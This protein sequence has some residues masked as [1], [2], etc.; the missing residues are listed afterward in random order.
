M[1]DAD[2]EESTNPLNFIKFKSVQFKEACR[3]EDNNGVKKAKEWRLI[4]WD[5]PPPGWYKFNTD[6]AMKASCQV[7]AA[8]GILR[9]DQGNWLVGFAMNLGNYSALVAEIWGAWKALNLAWKKGYRKIILEMD[10][11]VAIQ[12]ITNGTNSTNAATR[13]VLDIRRM[14]KLDW[15]VQVNH[16]FRE[17]NR[18]ADTLANISIRLPLGL[19]E[20]E[21]VPKEVLDIVYQDAVGV[22]FDRLCN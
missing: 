21:V 9:N 15:M 20:M 5:C 18:A 6:G 3:F 12:L 8:G 1:F 4:G 19:H 13:L 17:G 16:V 14:L 2:F 11:K 10:S 7:A 22:S